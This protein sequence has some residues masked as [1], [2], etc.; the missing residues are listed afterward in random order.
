MSNLIAQD[1]RQF[2]ND[3]QIQVLK[4]TVFKG[5]SD[6]ELKMFSYVCQRTGL[7]PF[8]RQIYAVKRWNKNANKFDTTFQTSI[9]GFRLIAQRTHGYQGQDGPWWCGD[10][11]VWKDVW[12]AKVIPRAGKVGVWRDGFK[13]ALWGIALWEEYVQTGK[14]QRPTPMWQKMPALMLAKCAESLA[15]RKAFPQELSGIY[16]QEE[17]KQA[18]LGETSNSMTQEK[19]KVNDHM[20]F[21]DQIIV[22]F[23]EAT[24]NWADTQTLN[25]LISIFGTSKEIQSKSLVEQERILIELKERVIDCP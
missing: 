16:T 20:N 7:D 5:A 11:G 12:L 25:H 21:Y 1:E 19:P 3:E 4:D 8:A 2:W 9:D 18:D 15:L 6:A 22:I 13:N 14:D 10:D 24:N 17:M 23:K